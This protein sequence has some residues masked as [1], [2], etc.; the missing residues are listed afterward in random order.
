MSTNWKRFARWAVSSLALVA[1]MQASTVLTLTPSSTLSGAGGT[2]VGW[3]FTLF[4]NTNFLVVNA[5]A[6]CV[7]PVS[8][9]A[10]TT[11]GAAIGTFTDFISAFNFFVVGPSP[12]STS[13]SQSFNSALHT[14][15]GSFAI[16]PG[17]GLGPINGQIV[18]DYS[19]FSVSPN[20]PNFDPN[21]DLVVADA[22]VTAST[23]VNIVATPEPASMGLCA[24]GLA[25]TALAVR[26]R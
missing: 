5:A 11:P 18:L 16:A 23:T 13:V 7:N 14:G 10:C 25:L 6:F 24:L 21:L 26:R 2:T 8:P 19:L 9:P 15:I 20:D 22:F 3:G 12:E 17:A 4:N 1:S